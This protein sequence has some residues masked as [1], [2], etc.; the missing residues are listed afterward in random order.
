[1]SDRAGTLSSVSNRPDVPA[2][3][4]RRLNTILNRL[5]ECHGEDAWT[6]VRWKVRSATVAHV[7]GGDDQLF[8]LTFRT[9]HGEVP[10]FENMGHPYFRCGHGDNHVGIM[11]DTHTDWQ[12]VRELL[13][14][15]YCLQAPNELADRVDRP[16]T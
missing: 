12:E 1:M 13:T 7:F 8:R 16:G 9:E 6:G 14:E 11:L 3:V 4:M 15:S 5:P 10:A 2:N